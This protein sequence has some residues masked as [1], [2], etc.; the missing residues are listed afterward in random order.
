MTKKQKENT[1]AAAADRAGCSEHRTAPRITAAIFDY[2]GTILDSMPMWR[3]V[4]SRFVRSLG[5]EPEPGLDERI[6]DMPLEE[7]AEQFRRY[8]AAGT[9]EEIVEQIME[10]VLE[11]YVK[12]LQ[13]KPGILRV[14][15]ELKQQHIRMCIAT[16]TPGYMIRAANKRLGLEKYFEDVFS[17]TDLGTHK[18]EPKIY[19]TAAAFLQSP[20]AQTLVFE[21]I[22]YAAETAAGAGFRVVGIFDE[23]SA[24]DRERI[25]KNCCL[26]LENYAAWPGLSLLQESLL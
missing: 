20:P 26:Y 6:R 13:P 5:A 25:E 10:V 4:P 21:D 3:S 12:E 19:E 7:S 15:E 17:C 14:L 9:G 23:D 22:F 2:D 24:D 18:R 16:H 11:S 1:G 8:G